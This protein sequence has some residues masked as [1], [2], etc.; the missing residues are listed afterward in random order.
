MRE[1]GGH[2]GSKFTPD[3]RLIKGTSL[4]GVGDAGNPSTAEVKDGRIVRIRPYD[5][6]EQFGK[7]IEQNKWTIEARGRKLCPPTRA[8][9]SPFGL[10]YKTR[11]Y[12][13]NRV[14][15]PLKRVDWDPKGERNPQNRGISKYVRISW[16]EAAQI[17]A[18]ELLR[19]RDT[20]GMSSVLVESDGHGEGKHVSYKGCPN[21]LVGLV[22][23]YTVQ[24]RNMDSW[25]GWHLGARHVWGCEP[26]GEMSPSANLYP[27][28]CEHA[29]TVLYWGCDSEVTPLGITSFIPTRLSYFMTTIGIKSVFIDPAFNYAAG[30]HADK[31]IPILPD[32]DAAFQLAIAYV[33]LTEGT[34]QKDYI[35]KHAYGFDK[36]VDYVMGREDGQPKTPAWASEKCG[37]AEWTIK[38]FARKWA[39]D[40]TSILH[41]NGGGYIRGPYASE[42]ARLE[43]MLLGMQGLGGPGVHQ[44]KMLEWD[45]ASADDWAI[46]Y[47]PEKM[48][49]VPQ[50]G[51]SDNM[52]A[53][54]E[55]L[56]LDPL[57]SVGR[58]G[59]SP[60]MAKRAPGFARLTGGHAPV[61]QCIPRCL[62][63]R[64]LLEDHLEWY[65]CA[66]APVRQVPN[67][68][69][70]TPHLY[71][72]A[73]SQFRK[74]EFPRPGCS[75]VHMIWTD[76]PCNVTCWNAGN[77]FIDG[78]R[79]PEVET[80]VAQHPWMEN[81]CCFADL[82]LP[83]ATKFEMNDLGNDHSSGTYVSVYLEGRCCAPI[84]ESKDDFWCCA[85]VAKKLGPDYYE[86]FTGNY[87]ED[88]LVKLLYDASGVEE[89]MTWEEL[90]RKQMVILPR[91]K[92]EDV[93]AIPPGL[94]VFHDDPGAYKLT[95]PTGL[96]EYS[97]SNMEKYLPD[98]P[99]R[100]PVPHWIESGPAHD[101]RLGGERGKKYTLLMVS[102]HG[103]WRM[104]AQCDDIVWNREVETMK[105]KGR[106][107]YSYEPCWLSPREAA[108]RGIQTGDIVKVFNDRGIVL[109]GA[110]VTE[111]IIE[112]ACYVD[113][114]ARLDPIIPGWLDRGGA[115]NTI[116]PLSNTSSNATGMATSGYLVEVAKVTDEEMEGW[117][118][119]YPA[120]FERKID[121]AFGICL[122]GWL[123]SEKNEER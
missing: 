58:G 81:D 96:L 44:A 122:D 28:I 9:I 84:G 89:F 95:T 101:E 17:C 31:W 38:A 10:T 33:W 40:T 103:R 62:V 24:V 98:D 15:Y 12:S 111:R 100:P 29:D 91:K 1:G 7:E 117:K 37:V 120:A 68:D 93:K 41:G 86:K 30:V 51:N 34:Y 45:V 2:M 107:G 26:L 22:G 18:D 46:P 36:F 48:I 25:E 59:V 83:V 35:E 16:D 19:M 5:F 43:V 119:D 23:P 52:P 71:S 116:C 64:A 108:K 76:T 14:K 113:H 3:K 75:R 102:N 78:Y 20:Y 32:T 73:E 110:Y 53:L 49:R 27:D 6:S 11:V 54:P 105:I 69:L 77:Q 50:I 121:Q 82:I 106:D 70:P 109:C 87:T 88:D 67:P 63:Q 55:D 80:I 79:S 66:W 21:R 56:A 47:Q 72:S 57:L 92:E 112:R 90:N 39:K 60:E 4:T 85:E 42:P 8:P 94:R 61:S 123:I 13:K 115:I 104:H 114:G 99:E 118:R 74:F 97:S 65:G